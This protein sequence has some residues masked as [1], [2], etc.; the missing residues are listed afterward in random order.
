MWCE[1]NER[2]K[3]GER[4]DRGSGTGIKSG[5]DLKERDDMRERR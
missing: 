5:N 3:L 4:I 2:E 1:G